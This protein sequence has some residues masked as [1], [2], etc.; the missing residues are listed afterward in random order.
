MSGAQQNQM[1]ECS[2]CGKTQEQVRKLIAGPTAYICDECIELCYDIIREGHSGHE[3]DV[4]GAE[5]P[6][7]K[8]IFNFLNQY[9]IGQEY[10]KMVLS[11]AVHNH[12]ERINNPVSD[13][14]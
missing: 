3:V 5:I 1:L 8:E 2:F 7:P 6:T 12:Y 10:A 14:V 9:V 13:D 4:S 11:V